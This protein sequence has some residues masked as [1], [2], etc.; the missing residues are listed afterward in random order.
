VVF[1]PPERL[2]G[3]PGELVGAPV[4]EEME[5]DM[6]NFLPVPIVDNYPVMAGYAEFFS[7]QFSCLAKLRKDFGWSGLE[8][9]VLGFG[10]DE[11]M[12]DI[13]GAMVRDHDDCF[14]LMK[15]LGRDLPVD[16]A[17]EY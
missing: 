14:G 16:N 7:H 10:H 17:C 6:V 3:E 2:K 15:D 4:R 5:V 12:D 8:V 9:G 1:A 11:Q 13:F